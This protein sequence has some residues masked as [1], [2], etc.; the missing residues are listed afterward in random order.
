MDINSRLDSL[1]L[2]VIS[3]SNS[4]S[5]GH[6]RSIMEVIIVMFDPLPIRDLASLLAKPIGELQLY[7]HELQS[8][9]SV[10]D[11]KNEPVRI[12]HASF[13]DFLVDPWF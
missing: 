7:L 3:S 13:Q 12:Y 5:H 10:P 11:D 2:K 4:Y 9:L 8:I 6:G 1:Y